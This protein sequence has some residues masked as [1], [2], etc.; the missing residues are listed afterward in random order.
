MKTITW[1]HFHKP[2]VT[3]HLFTSRLVT[4]DHRTVSEG[5]VKISPCFKSMSFHVTEILGPKAMTFETVA[6][7]K[8][9]ECNQTFG[10][11]IPVSTVWWKRWEWHRE[12]GKE[13]GH[14]HIQHIHQHNCHQFDTAFSWKT[15]EPSLVPRFHYGGSQVTTVSEAF[16]ESKQLDNTPWVCFLKLL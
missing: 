4:S 16:C 8:Y 7:H 14:F 6:A 1:L 10:S 11:E 15:G 5:S 13:F 2:S 12:D 3:S 9:T